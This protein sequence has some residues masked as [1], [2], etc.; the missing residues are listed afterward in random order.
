MYI[1]NT[2]ICIDILSPN[3]DFSY[4]LLYFRNIV[5]GFWNVLCILLN[6]NSPAAHNTISKKNYFN[7]NVENLLCNKCINI[8]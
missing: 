7:I 3:K 5:R 1:I 2:I 6:I 8:G 4:Y